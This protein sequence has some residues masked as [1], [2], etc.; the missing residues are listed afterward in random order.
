MMGIF[1]VCSDIGKREAMYP[2][3]YEY[4]GAGTWPGT[5]S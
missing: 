2:H 1:K 4:E 5:T 3:E